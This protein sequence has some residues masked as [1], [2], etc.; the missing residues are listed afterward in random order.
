MSSGCR[1]EKCRNS[2]VPAGRKPLDFS[3][4]A[5]FAQPAGRGLPCPPQYDA[6]CPVIPIKNV[7]VGSVVLALILVARGEKSRTAAQ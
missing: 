3:A 2:R 1:T 7:K 4:A 6:L 5:S